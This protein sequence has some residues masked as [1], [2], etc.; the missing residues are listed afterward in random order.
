MSKLKIAILI[1]SVLAIL[2]VGFSFLFPNSPASA[3]AIYTS[4]GV[5]YR[6]GNML[7]T[8]PSLPI[9]VGRQYATT[10]NQSAV[11]LLNTE[12]IGYSNIRIFASTSSVT[13]T[14]PASST[15]STFVPNA[16]DMTTVVFKN[17]TTTAGINLG[18]VAGSG[19]SLIKASSTATTTANGLIEAIF[20]RKYPT[21]TNGVCPTNCDIDVF[22]DVA[23]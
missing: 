7:K 15:L 8:N 23:I 6:S 16:G 12:L 22:V 21:A 5:W 13:V 19:L 20:I 14:L 2:W 11:T 10:T 1:L 3:P 18:L 4:S 17:A 9:T